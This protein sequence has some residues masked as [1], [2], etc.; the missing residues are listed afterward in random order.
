MANDSFV[1]VCLKGEPTPAA[2]V[3][4]LV[5]Q[6]NLALDQYPPGG[7]ESVM[8]RLRKEA[9]IRKVAQLINHH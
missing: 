3:N 1:G 7:F 5:I 8:A 9:H 2:V 6:G 4:D